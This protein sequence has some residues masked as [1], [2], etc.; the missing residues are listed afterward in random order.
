MTKNTMKK[1]NKGKQINTERGSVWVEKE[2]TCK[3]DA[4]KDGYSYAFRSKEYG[5]LYSN[6]LQVN[7]DGG[8]KYDEDEKR[9]FHSSRIAGCVR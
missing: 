5:P 9:V 6:Y 1:E 2:Y 3:E 4:I 7:A 8:E